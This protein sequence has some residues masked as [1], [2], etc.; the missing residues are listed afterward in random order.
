MGGT[1]LLSIF[2]SLLFLAIIF[3][4]RGVRFYTDWLWFVDVGYL[5]VFWTEFKTRLA[6]GGSLAA[7]G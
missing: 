1:P 6:L 3:F 7:A 2:A 5:N 4:G